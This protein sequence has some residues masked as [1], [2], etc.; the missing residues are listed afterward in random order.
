MLKLKIGLMV[1][2]SVLWAGTVWA[3]KKAP[4]P[5]TGQTTSYDATNPARDD[6][7]VQKGV[8][9]PPRRF[10]DTGKGTIT[11]NLTGLIWLKNANCQNS[12]N[13]DNWQGALDAVADLNTSGTMNGQDCGDTSGKSGSHRTDWR[14]P[15]IRELLSLVDYGQ[16]NLALPNGHPFSDFQPF[17]WSST[18]SAINAAFAWVV[19][20]F[21]GFVGD[22]DK[23]NGFGFVTAVR[24]P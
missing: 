24:G 17:Y 20:F 12:L 9:L 2:L 21:G 22:N 14:L 11:D 23:T 3:G 10:T 6:G 18:T 16:V 13:G 15:N 5:K 7:A 4:V 8:T 19:N 1:V